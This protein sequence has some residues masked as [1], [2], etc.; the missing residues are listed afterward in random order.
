MVGVNV[1]A[2]DTDAEAKRL[3][4]SL[5]QVFLNLMLNAMQHMGNRPEKRR[6]VR[7]TTTSTL[8]DDTHFVQI[9]FSDSGP[10]IH[11]KL[12]EKV[13][14]LGF[15][16]REDGSGLGLYIA[17]SLVESIHGSIT[18]EDSLME[19][20]TTFLVQL[21]ALAATLPGLGVTL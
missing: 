18:I 20:G 4:T 21:P 2:A 3:F 9:R 16:T 5:Q 17:R 8:V 7:V 14:E 15:T 10:G 6:V 12:W 11:H 13:F 1:F 19:L